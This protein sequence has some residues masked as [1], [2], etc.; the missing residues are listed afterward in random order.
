MMKTILMITLATKIISSHC[1]DSNNWEEFPLTDTEVKLIKEESG[2]KS[3]IQ[4]KN[5]Q[6]Q[7]CVLTPGTSSSGSCT[8]RSQR[9][10]KQVPTVTKVPVFSPWCSDHGDAGHLANC[11]E[12]VTRRPLVHSVRVC[13]PTGA[14]DCRGPCYQCPEYCEPVQ[15]SWCEVSHSISTV[16]MEKSDCDYNNDEGQ[17]GFIKNTCM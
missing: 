1:Q 6:N 5:N 17:D 12:T 16:V 14:P 13:T 15:Q 9:Q 7:T 2:S 8:W 3:R 10:C 11:H 4:L